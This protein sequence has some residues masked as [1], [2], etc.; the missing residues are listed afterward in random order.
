MELINILD[1]SKN[2]TYFEWLRNP[3]IIKSLTLDEIYLILEIALK[4]DFGTVLVKNKLPFIMYLCRKTPSLVAFKI[5]NLLISK[6]IGSE[7]I[8]NYYGELW[9][10][11]ILSKKNTLILKKLSSN[12]EISANPDEKKTDELLYET[13]KSLPTDVST[14]FLIETSSFPEIRSFLNYN[15]DRIL[16]IVDMY[17]EFFPE[18]N[19]ENMCY[20]STILGKMLER[21]TFYQ[22]EFYFKMLEN[23]KQSPEPIKMIGCGGSNLV[24]KIGEHVLKIG[25]TRNNKRSYINHRI[26]YSPVRKTHYNSDGEVSFIVEVMRYAYKG[27]TKEERDELKKSL[28]ASG[29]IWDD[30]KLIN[31]GLLAPGDNNEPLF[32]ND[33]SELEFVPSLDIEKENFQKRLRRVVVIDNDDIRRNYLISRG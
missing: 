25:E 2:K 28:N 15:Y 4:Y 32:E 18:L 26:M 13:L 20:G 7:E 16:R 21:E 6:K 17:K 3:S 12:Y 30:D 9:F 1:E 27:V 5:F 33:I 8:I 14:R 10:N 19:G 22:I 11:N 24:F 29:L 23:V 31:C